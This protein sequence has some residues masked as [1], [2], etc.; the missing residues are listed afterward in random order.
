MKDCTYCKYANWKT[1]TV[2]RLHPSGDGQC[3][4][5]RKALSV[6]LPASMYWTGGPGSICGGY[7]NRKKELT[8]DCVYFTRHRI[9]AP[10]QGGHIQSPAPS[11]DPA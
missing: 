6:R 3:M 10:P 8:E 4:Y 7:I 2:K 11:A 5:P 1:T 9:T